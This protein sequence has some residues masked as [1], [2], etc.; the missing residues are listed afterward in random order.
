MRYFK[1]PGCVLGLTVLIMMVLPHDTQAISMDGPNSFSSLYRNDI[2]VWDKVKLRQAILKHTEPVTCSN[3]EP[4]QHLFYDIDGDWID[5]G[6][7]SVSVNTD[8]SWSWHPSMIEGYL[9]YKKEFVLNSGVTVCFGDPCTTSSAHSGGG[10]E[11][12]VDRCACTDIVVMSPALHSGILYRVTP[13]RRA[14][15]FRPLTSKY[16]M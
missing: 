5:C 6:V 16:I 11:R 9:V 15:V 10:L 2:P 14:S 12:D 13:I 3:A 4:A 8:D 1:W 7:G